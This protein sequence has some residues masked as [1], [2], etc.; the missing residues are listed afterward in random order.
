MSNLK[1]YTII[2]KTEEDDLLMI[3]TIDN[4]TTDDFGLG[5]F[6]DRFTTALKNF[7]D[8]EPEEIDLTN[9]PDIFDGSWDFEFALDVYSC[10]SKILIME[11]FMY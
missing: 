8:V 5:I 4:I 11:T 6:K 2:E 7:Y 10:G 9:L 3:A 1:H